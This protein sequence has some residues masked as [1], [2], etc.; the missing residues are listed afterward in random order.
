MIFTLFDK[1]WEESS[2]ESLLQIQLLIA[3]RSFVTALGYQSPI[4]YNL[5]L[6]VLQKGIDINSPDELN[7]LEDSLQV[8]PPVQSWLS[9]C[10]QILIDLYGYW[11]FVYAKCNIYNCAVMGSYTFKCSL[12]GAST[13]CI[14]PLFSGSHRKKFW[15]LAGQAFADWSLILLHVFVVRVLNYAQYHVHFNV[16]WINAIFLL[17]FATTSK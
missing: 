9:S 16:L 10:H 13:T 17:K 4:C 15:S 6:P 14:L 12:N 2:G 5:I 3:L 8:K 7:L 1:V 11:I